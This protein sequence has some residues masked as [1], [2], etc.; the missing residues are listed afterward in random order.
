M[1]PDWPDDPE[2]ELAARRFRL[3]REEDQHELESMEEE[4][5]DRVLDLPFALLELQWRGDRVRVITPD[6]QFEGTV[7]HVGDDFLSVMTAP[8]TYVDARTDQVSGFVVTQRSRDGGRAKLVRDPKRFI[9]RVREVVDSVHVQCE[10]GARG[11][12]RVSGRV[13][14]V[15][16]DHVAIRSNEGSEWLL[17]LHSLHYMVRNER[18]ETRR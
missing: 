11:G 12:V 16:A 5:R 17:P 7:V 10:F 4:E 13:L 2:L 8:D 6:R 14:R 1:E 18:R 3:E 9:A 15:H